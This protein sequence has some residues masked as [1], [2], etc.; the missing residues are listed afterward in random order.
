MARCHPVPRIHIS[1][2]CITI[3]TSKSLEAAMLC[4]HY[5]GMEREPPCVLTIPA[6]IPC[7]LLTMKTLKVIGNSGHMTSINHGQYST[8]L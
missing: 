6:G 5:P 4:P 1:I 3:A 7:Q 8:T 2:T